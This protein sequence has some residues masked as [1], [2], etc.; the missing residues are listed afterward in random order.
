MK[1]N[2]LF[3]LSLLLC[4]SALSLV[5]TACGSKDE[6]ID[7]N[8]TQEFVVKGEI[9]SQDGNFIKGEAGLND[10]NSNEYKFYKAIYDQV[11]TIIKAQVWKVSFKADEKSQKMK[12][13][14]EIA[15]QRFT[16]MVKA[17]DDVQKKLNQTDKDAYKCHFSM[18][19]EMTAT[20]E[21]EI[22]SGQKTLKYA[23]NE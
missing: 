22:R 14:E 8:L 23:G 21:R 2:L 7:T 5:L 4:M 15:N 10:P 18:T 16:A 12:E 19:I 3:A 6:P 9:T 17:L 20:G 13:Q 11:T 1:R